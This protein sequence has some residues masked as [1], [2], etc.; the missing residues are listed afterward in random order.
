[1]GCLERDREVEAPL[2]W[3]QRFEIR[4][5]ETL[6]ADPQ[7]G[8]CDVVAVDTNDVGDAIL[9]EGLQPRA[10]SA[11]DV[12][13]ARRMEELDQRRHHDA[14]GRERA[15]GLPVEVARLEVLGGRLHRFAH[16]SQP[17]HIQGFPGPFA[18]LRL[19]REGSRLEP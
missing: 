8:S 9:H 17:S 5:D 1:M 18:V 14:G 3:W 4:R 13:H 6:F 16:V 11:A 2:E 15:L 12:K 19:A 10:R 7:V